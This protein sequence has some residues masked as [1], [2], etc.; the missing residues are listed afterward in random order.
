MQMLKI[1]RGLFFGLGIVTIFAS[2]RWSYAANKTVP[3]GASV[4]AQT[5][6]ASLIDINSAS[7]TT[8]MTLPEIGDVYAQK[9]I[10]G[11]PYRAKNE[12]VRRKII[13]QSTYGPIAGKLIAKQSKL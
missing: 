10:D 5:P 1:V 11:R 4:S 13:P 7:K 8:L 2:G 9:I 6:E 3:A 12:V